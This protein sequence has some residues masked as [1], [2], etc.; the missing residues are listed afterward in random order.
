M[1]DTGQLFVAWLPLVELLEPHV[2]EANAEELP[3]RHVEAVH[4]A[5]TGEYRRVAAVRLQQMQDGAA[6]S[7][8][9]VVESLRG[10]HGLTAAPQ[11]AVGAYGV[12]HIIFFL[13]QQGQIPALGVQGVDPG[14]FIDAVAL[15]L[16]GSQQNPVPRKLQQVGRQGLMALQLPAFAAAPVHGPKAVASEG[17]SAGPGLV[18]QQDS[19]AADRHGLQILRGLHEGADLQGLPLHQIRQAAIAVDDAGAVGPEG[20]LGEDLVVLFLLLLLPGLLPLLFGCGVEQR[21]VLVHLGGDQEAVFVQQTDGAHGKGQGHIG[22]GLAAPEVQHIVGCE[23]LLGLGPL[24]LLGGAY[25]RKDQP[26]LVQIREL[27]ELSFLVQPQAALVAVFFLVG[28]CDHKGGAFP[29]G[30]KPNCREEFIF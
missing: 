13:P 7:G 27:P 22:Q 3:V 6:L 29:V 26:L 9:Q 17:V 21:P 15:A 8:G 19:T 1:R 24:F 4:G 10:P 5:L 30:R 14:V 2:V 25:R 11:A 23:R 28:I 20:Q 12:V 16:G 18:G